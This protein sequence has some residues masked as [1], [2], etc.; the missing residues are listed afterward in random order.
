[1]YTKG[2]QQQQNTKFSTELHLSNVYNYEATQKT[3]QASI[4][5]PINRSPGLTVFC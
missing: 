5:S 1:M 4:L 3:S 2:K